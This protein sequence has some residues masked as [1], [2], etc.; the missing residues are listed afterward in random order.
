[1]NT[2]SL[3]YIHTYIHTCVLYIQCYII[4]ACAT[5]FHNFVTASRRR[6][7]SNC[8]WD[9]LFRIFSGYVASVGNSGVSDETGSDSVAASRSYSSCVAAGHWMEFL[10]NWVTKATQICALPNGFGNG[11][12]HAAVDCP[13]DSLIGVS[14]NNCEKE[15]RLPVCCRPNV[16][17]AKRGWQGGRINTRR[18][19]TRLSVAHML[20][21]GGSFNVEC[22]LTLISGFRRD[23]DEI[24][25]LM[26]YYAA[27]CGNCLLTFR[28]NVSVSSSR[29]KSP[30]RKERKP[31]TYNVDSYWKCARCSNQ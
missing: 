26:G 31:A 1:M 17:W 15:G 14:I 28:D 13:S 2:I 12:A 10:V 24:W 6:S 25:A 9:L 27:S 23:V 30:S 19:A 4:E 29:V 5:H 20:Y 21:R 3:E 11:N 22:V 18:N 16:L 7:W 8:E